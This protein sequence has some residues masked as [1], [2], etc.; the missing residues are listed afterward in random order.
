MS[1]IKI[2]F[3]ID[4][5]AE[6]P[7]GTENQL[8]LLLKHIDKA[9]FDP[10]LILLRT[11]RQVLPEMPGVH[12][13]VCHIGSF[14]S[15]KSCYNLLKLSRFLKK[16][17]IRIVQTYFRDG[18]IVGVMAAWFAGVA[19][20]ISSRRNLGSWHN[21]REIL[22]VRLLNR[23]VTCFIANSQAI[24]TYTHQVERVPLEKIEVI[25]NGYDANAD[26]PLPLPEQSAR[27]AGQLDLEKYQQVIVQ[28]SNLREI[29]RID[30]LIRAAGVV[31]A[32]YPRTLFLVIGEGP[33]RERLTALIN[34]LHLS[35]HVY[36]AGFRS[37]VKE[38]LKQGSIGILCSDS[39]GLSNTI[40]EY[41][42]A[43]L[44][45]VCTEVGGNVELIEH[46]KQGF[47]FRPGD[48]Q[49]LAGC[50]MLLIQDRK[51]ASTLGQAAAQRA[52]EKFGVEQY[53]ASSEKFFLEHS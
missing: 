48:Y 8:L 14:L 30:V 1:K 42:A 16:E 17:R 6:H 18:N 15:L 27:P 9:R 34:E 24:K 51:L 46:N 11:G 22:I 40:I 39:E 53:I 25:Y 38:I 13:H 12:I 35:N 31:A 5:I 45:V 29:K 21:R 32:R 33:E 19:T 49:D 50:L 26:Y 37:D 20:I 2:A 4:L 10:Y 52:L 41:M 7:G 47:L 3:V 36:L 43:G 23:L 44:P 28:V